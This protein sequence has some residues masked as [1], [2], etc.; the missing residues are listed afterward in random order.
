MLT[1]GTL[2]V[3]IAGANDLDKLV[4]VGEQR[5]YYVLECGQQRSRSKACAENGCNPVWNTAHKFNLNQE[6]GVVAIIK[7]EVTK[8]VIGQGV[9]ELTRQ[10]PTDN[11]NGG[12]ILHEQ[13][14][15]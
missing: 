9:I 7:D 10:V 11:S 12:C 5:P 15:G 8:G 4:T 13:Q 14:W 2:K 1:P 6:A 3:L